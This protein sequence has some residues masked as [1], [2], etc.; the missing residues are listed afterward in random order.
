MSSSTSKVGTADEAGIGGVEPRR[1]LFVGARGIVAQP[2]HGVGGL[3]PERAQRA[4]TL[5][6]HRSAAVPDHDAFAR[7]RG[8][9]SG[10]RS[11]AE[12]VARAQ[13]RDGI[14]VGGAHLHHRAELFG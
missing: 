4:A 3:G 9:R 1:L 14:D 8:V 12:A 6:E 11:A 5:V 10:E 13:G 7:A 2:L